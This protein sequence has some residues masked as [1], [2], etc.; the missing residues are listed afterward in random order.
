MRLGGA[1]RLPAWEAPL[2]VKGLQEPTY[3]AAPKVILGIKG[4]MYEENDSQLQQR[5]DALRG[6]NQSLLREVMDLRVQLTA[7]TAAKKPVVVQRDASVQAETSAEVRI[8]SVTSSAQ[9]DPSDPDPRRRTS[10]T[11]TAPL[12]PP[13]LP[14]FVAPAPACV[15]VDA[16]TQ[17]TP[18]ARYAKASQTSRIVEVRATGVQADCSVWRKDAS[19]TADFSGEGESAARRDLLSKIDGLLAENE[20][21]KQKHVTESAGKQHLHSALD[22]MEAR[23]QRLQFVSERFAAIRSDECS[24]GCGTVAEARARSS[25]LKKVLQLCERADWDIVVL[26]NADE[27]LRTTCTGVARPPLMEVD[28]RGADLQTK[29]TVAAPMFPKRGTHNSVLAPVQA[30]Q[31]SKG[32]GMFGMSDQAVENGGVAA[33]Q[34]NRLRASVHT[35]RKNRLYGLRNTNAVQ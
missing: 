23:L 8:P 34:T 29:T 26:P 31:L 2:K 3:K 12:P 14:S 17:Y 16:E 19:C 9:T 11:Q 10:H 32:F 22:A 30:S 25:W 20:A 13:R 27:H 35:A 15:R 28:D 4:R 7:A 21:V 33:V 18:P 6:E 5:Y 1:R 24:L